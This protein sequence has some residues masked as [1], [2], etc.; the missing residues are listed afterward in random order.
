MTEAIGRYISIGSYERIYYESVGTGKPVICVPTAAAT[1][2]EY[3][4]VLEYFGSRGYQAIALDPPGHGNSYPNLADL[5]IPKTPDEYVDFIWSFAK[6]KRF[7]KPAFIGCAVSGSA[8]LLLAAKYGRQVS[9]VVSGGGNPDLRIGSLQ[10]NSLNHPGINTA[11]FMESTT[12]GLCG[13]DE[14]IEIVNEAIWHNARNIVPEVMETEL[15]IYNQLDVTDDLCRIE[16][17]VLHIRGEF[18]ISVPDAAYELIGEHIHTV[19]QVT[20]DKTGHYIPIENPKGFC[21]AIEKFFNKY[22]CS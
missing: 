7:E 10:M 3:R 6:E 16:C 9:A 19:E 4:H 21:E 11:D 14:P 20:L 15:D 2:G 22:Y 13:C 1:A 8:M 5:S 17:P 12:P 18:D